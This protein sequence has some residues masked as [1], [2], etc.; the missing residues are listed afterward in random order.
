MLLSGEP[1]SL[2]EAEAR[3]LFLAYDSESK[4]EVPER[5]VLIVDS[6]ADP[7]MVASRIAFARRVG[8]LV[9]GGSEATAMAKGRTIRL[10]NFDLGAKPN[11]DAVSFLSGFEGEVEL[12]NPDL[13]LILVRGEREYL[14]LTAPG[15]MRQS[16]SLRRPRARAYFHP[17][18]IFPK[19]ARALVNLSR[20]TEGQV[21]LDPFCGTGSLP[22]EAALIGAQVVA[23]DRA[24][25]MTKGSLANMK[26]YN[27]LWLGVVRSDTLRTPLTKVDAVATDV[28]YGRASSTMG[29]GGR[30]ILQ[31]ALASLPELLPS[32]SRMVL[33]HSRDN[34]V[35]GSRGLRV[36][37]EHDLHVHKNL[38]RRISVMRRR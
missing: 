5:R 18:A 29:V 6:A 21:F 13:E 36:E 23:S 3:A 22:L 33:M 14:A 7:F 34:P 2:P 11:L 37:E 17:S 20:V 19:L 4:F 24:E 12:K 25:K 35:E 16:W 10:R 27:Q 28:P 15:G 1:T 30:Q 32:G 8:K 31:G 9:E 26:G 38:T